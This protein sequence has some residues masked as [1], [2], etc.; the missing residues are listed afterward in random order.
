MKNNFLHISLF[1][2]FTFLTAA[3]CKKPGSS[4]PVDQL[5]PE[6]QTGANTFGCLIDGEVFLPKG[7]PL[8]GPV[9]KAQYQFVGGKQGFGVSAS[10][11]QNDGSIKLVGIGGDSISLSVNTFDLTKSNT[12]GKYYGGY[13]EISFSSTGNDFSTND[14]NRGQLVIKKFDTVNQ[15]VSGTFWFD[16]KNASGQ[17]VHITEGRFDMPYVR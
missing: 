9:K 6:T 10:Q 17:I 7:N 15:I 4:N 16:A 11:K 8:A 1:F 2:F 3:S 5:P 13:S 12:A 14:I